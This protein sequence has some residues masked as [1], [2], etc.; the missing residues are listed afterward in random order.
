MV[1]SDSLEVKVNDSFTFIC[2]KSL[3]GK[4]RYGRETKKDTCVKT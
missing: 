1:N 2:I 4:R 3:T